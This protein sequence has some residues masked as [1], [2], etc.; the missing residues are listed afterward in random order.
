MRLSVIC[1]YSNNIEFVKQL[2]SQ[3]KENT[4][5]L[6]IVTKAIKELETLKADN[7]KIVKNSRQETMYKAALSKA[8]GE[9]V[10]FICAGDKVTDNYIESALNALTDNADYIP[11]KWEFAD[12]HSFKFAGCLS[13]RYLFGNIYKIGFA[14]KLDYFSENKEANNEILRKHTGG[15]PVTDVIYKH[16][17]G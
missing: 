6:V 5:I 16:Y 11:F 15:A 1:E 3:L 9:F 12:W 10:S 14:K 7:V 17:K 13:A 4:E 8:Q 2:I